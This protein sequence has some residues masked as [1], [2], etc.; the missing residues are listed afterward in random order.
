MG[1]TERCKEFNLLNHFRQTKKIDVL[2]I[3]YVQRKDLKDDSHDTIE[4]NEEPEKSIFNDDNSW[5]CIL[6]IN[7]EGLTKGSRFISCDT[8]KKK[9]LGKL[10]VK[11]ESY[12][13]KYV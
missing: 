3:T 2:D 13:R 4:F 8:S 10:L 11:H 1:I 5:I 9:A 6:Y 7:N 12:L